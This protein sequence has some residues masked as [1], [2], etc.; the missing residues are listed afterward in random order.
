[1]SFLS[2]LS[3]RWPG[4]LHCFAELLL[5]S[6]PPRTSVLWTPEVDPIL[7]FL[8]PGMCEIPGPSVSASCLPLSD[9]TAALPHPGASRCSAP[10]ANPISRHHSGSKPQLGTFSFPSL[11]FPSL[12]TPFPSFSFLPFLPLP[13]PP[14]PFF[15]PLASPPPLSLGGLLQIWCCSFTH[16]TFA[17][18]FIC[19]CCSSHR[20]EQGTKCHA[21]RS[22]HSKETDAINTQLL[23]NLTGGEAQGRMR[24][25]E[26]GRR[27]D[28]FLQQVS[29]KARL[30]AET[31][32]TGGLGQDC[33]V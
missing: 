16:Q 11:L 25:R 19:R 4:N 24:T 33:S 31:W 8:N 20:E 5:D 32:R 6:S 2:S 9:T 29:R 13:F 23:L 22:R 3:F 15:P 1:M 12:P 18:S 27:R 30:R 28:S 17:E 21:L 14:I 10:P 26:Q 7:T